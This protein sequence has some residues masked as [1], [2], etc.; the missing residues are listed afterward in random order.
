MSIW[1]SAPSAWQAYR[2]VFDR[3]L[4]FPYILCDD[5]DI[6]SFSCEQFRHTL[7]HAL[8]TTGHNSRLVQEV[9][10]KSCVALVGKLTLPSTGN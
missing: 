1:V 9:L 8:G 10:D 5:H 4:Q 7:A 6:C 2:D 3:H